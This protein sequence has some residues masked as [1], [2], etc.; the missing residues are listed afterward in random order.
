M[1]SS[2]AL[3]NSPENR[4]CLRSSSHLG[5]SLTWNLDWD[6]RACPPSSWL[7]KKMI[8]CQAARRLFEAHLKRSKLNHTSIFWT[9]DW[10]IQKTGVCERILRKLNDNSIPGLLTCHSNRRVKVLI[11]CCP[12]TWNTPSKVEKWDGRNLVLCFLPSSCP[13]PF[14]KSTFY[15]SSTKEKEQIT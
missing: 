4:H 14:R 10:W 13:G 11:W 6:Q 12:M 3:G 1:A 5:S 2:L 7:K 8:L 15:L 9:T